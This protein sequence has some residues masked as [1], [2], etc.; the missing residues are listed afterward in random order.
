M[1]QADF[2]DRI[3]PVTRRYLHLRN[4]KGNDV[5][6]GDYLCDG[7]AER[8]ILEWKTQRGVWIDE[9]DG[10]EAEKATLNPAF[11][12]LLQRAGSST[13][14]FQS[15]PDLTT[16]EYRLL[17]ESLAPFESDGPD[18]TQEWNLFESY[19]NAHDAKESLYERHNLSNMLNR[20][21]HDVVRINPRIRI[22]LRTPSLP[23]VLFI[24]LIL[25]TF[26]LSTLLLLHSH[27]P[28]KC[29]ASQTFVILPSVGACSQRR[30]DSRRRRETG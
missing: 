17:S 29:A 20:W 4:L 13:F 12:N 19:L 8:L 21:K 22:S 11:E 2:L 6:D 23:C 30:P 28:L 14:T 7:G 26:L 5:A 15:V 18:D 16:H 9:R 24:T 25:S 27:H 3:Q 10:A 1:F